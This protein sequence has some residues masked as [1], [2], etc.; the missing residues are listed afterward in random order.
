MIGDNN[1][2]I[3]EDIISNKKT[4]LKKKKN[5][6]KIWL[7]QNGKHVNLKYSDS[8]WFLNQEHG[9]IK[10]VNDQDQSNS[11]NTM[12]EENDI[13]N[14]DTKK[15]STEQIL[16]DENQSY[17]FLPYTLVYLLV[18]FAA[19]LLIYKLGTQRK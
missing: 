2:N 9:A 16:I 3:E 15:R 11:F 13:Y 6:S 1:F 10:N 4:N 8:P 19:L 7:V 18:F 17:N 12:D 14:I 5:K